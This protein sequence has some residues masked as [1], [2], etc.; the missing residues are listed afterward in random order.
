MLYSNEF[1]IENKKDTF[2]SL[3][4]KNP[5]KELLLSLTKSGILL[6]GTITD[7]YQCIQFRANSINTL[8]TIENMQDMEMYTFLLNIFYC[9]SKQLEYLIKKE[10]KCF[11]TLNPANLIIIDNKKCIYISN[12]LLSLNENQYLTIYQ[13]FLKSIIH[14]PE[15]QKINTLP[16]HIHFKTIYY[17]LAALIVNIIQNL[18]KD[19]KNY[20]KNTKLFFA[21]KR[22]LKKKPEERAIL[23]V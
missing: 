11:Y 2:Y 23:F 8:P 15:L 16:I 6:G 10:N 9:L 3:L 14:S 21:L 1:Q 13:P 17:S 12:D 5:N 18:G 22:C 20:L 4:L 19:H 7:N